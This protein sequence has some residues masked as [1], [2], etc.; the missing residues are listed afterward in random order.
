METS[1]QNDLETKQLEDIKILE[2]WSKDVL[3]FT[4]EALGLKPAECLESLK[5]RKI[6]YTDGFGNRREALL[7]DEDGR[8]VY[9]DLTFYSVDMFKNQKPDEF[10]KY[11]GTRLTWQQTVKLTAY[12]RAIN[13]F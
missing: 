11:N 8:L 6:P 5:G 4:E 1:T 7:F 9:H 3:L 2:E 12:D 10:K 13:T